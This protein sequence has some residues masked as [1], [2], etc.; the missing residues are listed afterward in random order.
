MVPEEGVVPL[1]SSSLTVGAEGE[2]V[3]GT[4]KLRRYGR[5]IRVEASAGLPLV[6]SGRVVGGE[7][8]FLGVG[9]TMSLG[10]TQMRLVGRVEVTLEVRN[11]YGHQQRQT[12]ALFAVPG[13]PAAA[14]IV[15]RLP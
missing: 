13:R 9:E 14:A 12:Q 3:K 4:M 2:R 6:L 5:G 10:D 1:A 8:A 15:G 7:E 11:V